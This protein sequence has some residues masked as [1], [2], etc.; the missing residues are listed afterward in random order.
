VDDLAAAH[1]VAIEKIE[2]GAFTAYNLGTGRGYSVREV[3]AAAER[4]TGRKIPVVESA[5]RPGD[6]P[7]LV[8][9]AS[10]VLGALGWKARYTDIED[11]VRSAWRWLETHPEGFGE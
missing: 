11:V 6:P 8:A 9:D 2:E 1:R 10:K 5:R 3:I 7:A 4:V